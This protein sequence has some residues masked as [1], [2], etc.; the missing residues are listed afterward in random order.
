MNDQ[1]NFLSWHRYYIH[2]FEKA[3]HD[4]CNY[5]PHLSLPYYNWG[6][7]ASSILSAPI[8]SGSALSMGGNGVYGT[9]VPLY[10]PSAA[11]PIITVPP[12]VGGGCVVSGPW[13]EIN[14]TVNLG[15]IAPVYTN[16][17]TNP[18]ASGLGYNPRCQR[19]DIS[20]FCAGYTSD[21]YSTAL[22]AGSPD[23][24]TFQTVLQGQFDQ[25]KIGLHTAG[26]FIVG[27]DP[28]GDF[29]ASPGDPFFWLHHGQVDRIWWIWQ[30]LGLGGA[31]NNG[32]AN[33]SESRLQAIAGTITFEN[34][35]PSRDARLND[36]IDIGVNAGPILISDAM[37]TLDG[38]FCYIYR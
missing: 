9:H 8:W 21:A 34:V 10:F 24:A 17:T 22:I 38:P 23:I 20:Q 7:Y 25:G 16:I 2:V 26:H 30:N 28:G 27:G 14:Y 33:G 5:P 12:S 37:S 6:L 32:S 35:P 3:L 31:G 4:E 18:L 29:Y 15:P 1:G 36:T 13:A 19:R 11:D